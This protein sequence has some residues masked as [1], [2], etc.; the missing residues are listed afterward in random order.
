MVKQQVKLEYRQQLV[1]APQMQQAVKI[2]ALPT[3]QLKQRI[4]TELEKNPLL[5]WDEEEIIQE[6]QKEV[7]EDPGIELNDYL[8]WM[9][10]TMEESRISKEKAPPNYENIVSKHISLYEYLFNQLR[11]LPLTKKEMAVSETIIDLIDED[12]YLNSSLTSIAEFSKVDVKEV[13]KVLKLV[14]DLEP[15]G[16]GARDLSEA[17]LIQAKYLGLD[18]EEPTLIEL[19][20]RHLKDAQLKNYGRIAKSLGIKENMAKR[21]VRL[22]SNLEPKPGRLYSDVNPVYINPDIIVRNVDK[23]FSVE[24][25]EE[26]IPRLRISSYY[27]KILSQNVEEK[28][29]NYIKKQMEGAVWFLKCIT[30]R[31]STLLKVSQAIFERQKP[32]LFSGLSN[33]LPLRMKEIAAIC[34]IDNSTVSRAVSGKYA[35]TPWGIFPLKFFFASSI[36]KDQGKDVSSC[37][38]RERIKSLISNENPKKPLSDQKL[39]EILNQDNLQVVRRTITK[40]RQQMGIL[41]SN[42]RRGE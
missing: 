21:L 31:E 26:W 42:L 38:I 37:H 24:L 19:I 41:P 6:E 18:E 8:D 22:L 16:V 10:E 1:F 30:E 15:V 5:E 13:E 7:E 32:F 28:T 35:Q 23:G 4:Q 40:Y 36:A 25:N 12:G 33:L 3:L 14:Q 11:L 2:L 29:I 20:K 9:E 17:L 27:K 34:K 39:S